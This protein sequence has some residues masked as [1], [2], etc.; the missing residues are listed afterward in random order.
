MR[1]DRIETKTEPEIYFQG[2]W[3]GWT[4]EK[5]G[6]KLGETPTLGKVRNEK[7]YDINGD[8]WSSWNTLKDNIDLAR[9]QTKKQIMAAESQSSIRQGEKKKSFQI[10]FVRQDQDVQDHQSGEMCCSVINL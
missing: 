7:I 1:N 10:C 6:E 5:Q 8:S 4:I 2:S 3:E 9:N